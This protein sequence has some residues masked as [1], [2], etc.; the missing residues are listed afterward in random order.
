MKTDV[1][2][3]IGNSRMKWGLCREDQVSESASLPLESTY[4]WDEQHQ[5]WGLS[6]ATNWALSGVN[7]SALAKFVSWVGEHKANLIIL[8]SFRH[9]PISVSV[10]VPEKVGIDRLLNAVAAKHRVQREISLFIID[11][12]TAVTVDWVDSN[13]AFRGGAIFPG[14]RLMA[15]SLHE[16]TALLPMLDVSKLSSPTLPGTTTKAAMKA[17]IFWAVAGGI[18]AILRCLSVDEDALRHHA[19]FLTGGDAHLLEPVMESGFITWPEMTLE[20]IRLSAEKLL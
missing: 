8:S 15:K 2:V 5:K 3:D 6:S 19:I 4:L 9:L 17:G 18:K 13:G 20:G 16:H 11:A 1:V 10:N 14:L 7:P 12:G